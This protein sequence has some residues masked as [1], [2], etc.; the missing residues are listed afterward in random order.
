MQRRLG[1]KFI[2][3]SD[4][5]NDNSNNPSNN[6]SAK[7]RVF[8]SRP[9]SAMSAHVTD[10]GE[11][12]LACLED[13]CKEQEEALAPF[14]LG[15]RPLNELMPPNDSMTITPDVYAI[16]L[17]QYLATVTAFGEVL[18]LEGQLDRAR[19]LLYNSIET[20]D[21]Y[22]NGHFASCRNVTFSTTSPSS[23][24]Y[25]SLDQELIEKADKTLLNYSQQSPLTPK[26]VKTKVSK[27]GDDSSSIMFWWQCAEAHKML[28]QPLADWLKRMSAIFKLKGELQRALIMAQTSILFYQLSVMRDSS[29]NNLLAAAYALITSILHEM[30]R[31]SEAVEYEVIALQLVAA[32]TCGGDTTS[33]EEACGGNGPIE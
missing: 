28:V 3:N 10:Y 15:I 5:S 33:S 16:A 31:A 6:G 19:S 29:N 26:A 1:I 20:I 17:E 2:D 4:D 13:A 12:H 23:T 11:H 24:L 25:A 21:R 8:D 7:E 9:S 27:T 14:L 18:Q 32:F 30:G 22:L